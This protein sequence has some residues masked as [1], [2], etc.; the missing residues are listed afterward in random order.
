LDVLAEIIMICVYRAGSA[1]GDTGPTVFFRLKGETIISGNTDDLL[2]QFGC[3]LGST[4]QMTENA[5]TTVEA[6]E[7]MTPSVVTGIRHIIK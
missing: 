2:K 6:W 7:K 1:A 3:A 4:I 5:L